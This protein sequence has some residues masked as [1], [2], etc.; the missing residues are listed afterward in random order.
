M[1]KERYQEELVEVSRVVETLKLEEEAKR[2]GAWRGKPFVGENEPPPVPDKENAP[3]D[4][5][6]LR[7]RGNVPNKGTEEETGRKEIPPEGKGPS[8]FG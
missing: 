6:E 2:R 7:Q 4:D 5:G 8:S 1:G 3:V